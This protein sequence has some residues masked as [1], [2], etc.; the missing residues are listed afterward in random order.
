MVL[1]L[2]VPVSLNIPLSK[3][4]LRVVLLGASNLDLLETPLWQVDIAGA[5]VAAQFSVLQPEGSGQSP[6]LGAVI[7]GDILDN[8]D[9][10]V[11]LRI[12]NSGVSVARNLLVRLGD[13]CWNVVRVE[14]AAGLGV[15]K[16]E[17]IAVSNELRWRFLIVVW[18]S[19]VW[20]EP[21]LVVGILVVIASDLLLS[22]SIWV[23]LDVGVEKTTTIS[24]V[25]D[26]C[27][28]SVGDLKWRILPDL[29]TSEVGLEEGAHLG[30]S[31]SGVL[32]NGKVSGEGEHVDDD[33]DNNQ[34]TNSGHDVRTKL[35]L[36]HLVVSKLVPEILN[37]VKT[38]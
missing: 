8:L 27:A 28:G 6:D 10:P 29:G 23:G 5:K 19:S 12:T 36:W 18:L 38:N 30:V 24:H 33:W 7:R 26:G 16:T 9:S 1:T 35:G 14:V 37:G 34:A 31:R 25:L 22:R 4:I 32:E 11:V 17:N 2:V 20:V 13:W 3:S 15:D 21:P